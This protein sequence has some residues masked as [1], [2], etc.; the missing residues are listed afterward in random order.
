M[1][2]D[3]GDIT[4]AITQAGVEDTKAAV[5]AMAEAV[6]KSSSRVRSESTST[7][8]LPG[9]PQL[10]QLRFYMGLMDKYMK[11]KNFRLEV[12]NTLKI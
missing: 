5:K 4:Q 6:V 11:F 9:R 3:Q 2:S 10:M 7:G 1:V 12:N 8:L